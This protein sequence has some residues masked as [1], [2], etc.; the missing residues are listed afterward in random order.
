MQR[1]KFNFFLIACFLLRS[2]LWAQSH[3]N[4]LK[5]GLVLSGGGAKALAHVGLLEVMDEEGL[6]PDFIS[7]TSM[8]AVV[9]ALYAMGYSGKA[10]RKE[11]YKVHWDAI[12]T[13][14]RPR[15]S[16]PFSDR[17]TEQRYILSFEIQNKRL[18]IPDG[19]NYGQQILNELDRLTIGAHHIR[20]F[21]Q[22]P[23]PFACIAT[24]LETGARTVLDTGYLPDAMR[25]TSSFPT[26]Y[27]P[28]EFG[29]ALL[30][31]G[32][33]IE[34]LPI[35][36]AL[37]KGMNVIIGSDVQNILRKK[38][39]LGSVFRVLEQISSF[40]NA[41]NFIRDSCQ[42]LFLVEPNI[43]GAG[44]TTFD[45][46]DSIFRSGYREA[47]KYRET[48]RELAKSN[49][50]GGQKKQLTAFQ[51]SVFI[52]SILL[53]N[54][55][56]S[57]N[58]YIL[59]KL[60]LRSSMKL[61]TRQIVEGTNRIWGSQLFKTADFKLWPVPDKSSYDLKL[62]LKPVK[63]LSKIR[64]GLHYDDDF[65][66][67]VLLNYTQRNFIFQGSRLSTDLA[68]GTNP[69]L[70]VDYTLDRQYIP[71]IRLNLRSHRFGSAI[72]ADRELAQAFTY[73]DVSFTS[74]I[75]SIL[76]DRMLLGFGAQAENLIVSANRGEFL[77]KDYNEFYINYLATLQL[78]L[79]ENEY[80]P[81]KGFKLD[82]LYRIHTKPENYSQ[83]FEPSSVLQARFL[84]VLAL[85]R[86]GSLHFKGSLIT[87]LGPSLDYPYSIFLGGLGQNYIQYMNPFVG[88]RFMELSGRN[89]VTAGVDYQ[90]NL[91]GNHYIIAKANW[92]AIESEFNNLF[93]SEVLLDGYGFSYAYNSPLGPLQFTIMGSSN[94]T[95]IYTYVNLGFWF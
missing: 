4:D 5:I 41:A 85:N 28:Y 12:L 11:M 1:Y 57:N 56:V 63:S 58:S 59:S 9:G 47:A 84:E 39:D 94:H 91:T 36:L 81:K 42:A 60:G 71:S 13:N 49:R 48:I 3:D 55:E 93:N 29:E 78:D 6:R 30:V 20:D 52:E 26:L 31:D 54:L 86:K 17:S 16:L 44:V 69:R 23:I 87:T 90:Y 65:Q 27:S 33:I 7:G 82:A 10:I 73:L 67:A 24:D 38:E 8:G 70:W 53:P 22:L 43:P 14:D 19:I 21:S 61:S 74:T 37:D 88:Y 34:N 45:M 80:F 62:R 25:A 68:L 51:D 18:Q 64:L 2:I 79:L 83:Q 40:T 77:P 15:L 75:Q 50:Q 72:Y 89:A 35:Q 46:L 76:F 92:G 32:G 95:N 66:T